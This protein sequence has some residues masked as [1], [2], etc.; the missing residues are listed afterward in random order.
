MDLTEKQIRDILKK[1]VL[2]RYLQFSEGERRTEIYENFQGK[3]VADDLYVF[4]NLGKIQKFSRAGI[5]SIKKKI[6]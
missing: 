3:E 5:V 1:D 6:S 4:Q 2:G